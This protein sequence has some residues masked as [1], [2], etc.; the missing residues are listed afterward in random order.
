MGK[1]LNHLAGLTLAAFLT[2]S[3]SLGAAENDSR[4]LS[5][6]LVAHIS[7]KSPVDLIEGLDAFLPAVTDGSASAVPVGLLSM[8][9]QTYLRSLE[10]TF[11]F[12]DEIHLLATSASIQSPPKGL[13]VLLL[14][15]SFDAFLAGLGEMGGKT[16]KSDSEGAEVSFGGARKVFALD[17]GDGRVALALERGD[18][19][20]ALEMD[21][22]GPI[23][24]PPHP[25]DSLLSIVVSRRAVNYRSGQAKEFFDEFVRKSLG[26]IKA[27]D[28]AELDDA[29][30]P[31]RDL[32]KWEAAADAVRKTLP[33]VLYKLTDAAEELAKAKSL[34]LDVRL[35]GWRLAMTM[36]L[37]TAPDSFLGRIAASLAKLGGM[38][39]ELAS[40]IDQEAVV[41][42]MNAPVENLIPEARKIIP[43]WLG[44]LIRPAFPEPG[45][46]LVG[47][48]AGVIGRASGGGVGASW[49]D[50]DGRQIQLNMQRSSD[51]DAD[52]AAFLAL[53][54]IINA[55]L[56]KILDASTGGLKL[57][58]E[59]VA[60]PSGVVLRLDIEAG[61]RLAKLLRD[62]QDDEA[63]YG[64]GP[65]FDFEEILEDAA[66]FVGKQGDT[67]V[68]LN[69]KMSADA[70]FRRQ[71]L[72]LVAGATKVKNPF[73]ADP[74]AKKLLG[75][76]RRAQGGVTLIDTGKALDFLVARIISAF[77]K[78]GLPVAQMED[79][80][81]GYGDMEELAGIGFGAD[82]GLLYL[83][84]IIPAKLINV[85]VRGSEALSGKSRGDSGQ[86]DDSEDG[87][88]GNG[89]DEY[90]EEE[91]D[92]GED[93]GGEDGVEE[94]EGKGL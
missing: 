53:P 28:R 86:F 34:R 80:E 94:P 27:P 82:A 76:L 61:S 33:A 56:D 93:D 87:E 35:D 19:E 81:L 45:E 66:L 58:G 20:Y 40:R 46:A 29:P 68:V 6:R 32:I 89:Y 88:D 12:D 90:D 64:G 36:G 49:F 54:G 74:R 83:E 9:S 72:A 85:I 42:N 5:D 71:T 25:A 51:P 15:D 1:F 17:L 59:S 31:L 43:D 11:L 60:E 70:E 22:G 24:P 67:L 73:I 84:Y 65:R 10:K 30:E 75:E 79:F 13:V 38:E 37:E 57:V 41:I 3:L 23:L 26:E 47:L 4:F 78:A 92:Y 91:E 7:I 48:L 21:R 69:G 62:I 77:E 50:D 8:L 55:M 14:A 39:N 52:L 63:R 2:V 44:D 18:I 16:V